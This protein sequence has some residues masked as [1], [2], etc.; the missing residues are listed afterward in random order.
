M[1]VG[2]AYLLVRRTH[3]DPAVWPNPRGPYSWSYGSDTGL[4]DL[5]SRCTLLGVYPVRL[6][7]LP[8]WPP[9]HLYVT[10]VQ[11]R[12]PYTSL[13]F[14]SYCSIASPGV[15]SSPSSLQRFAWPLRRCVAPFTHHYF[16]VLGQLG[17]SSLCAN[18]LV[19]PPMKMS[20]PFASMH[21]MQ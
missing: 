9:G 6:W 4:W 8:A 19:L 20:R 17:S 1:D 15:I 18:I 12:D 10:I 5:T 21:V 16:S 3:A 7:K 14:V 11:R 13:K 2:D